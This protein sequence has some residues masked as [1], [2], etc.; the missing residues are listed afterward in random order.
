LLTPDEIGW[1]D[2]YHARIGPALN[3]LL[4]EPE[5]DWLA[6]A[7]RPLVDRSQAP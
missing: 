7:T 4:D 5:R 2:S 3:H 1:L 6:E